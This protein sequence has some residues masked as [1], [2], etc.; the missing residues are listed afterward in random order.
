MLARRLSS[1]HIAAAAAVVLVILMLYYNVLPDKDATVS[2][3]YPPVIDSEGQTSPDVWQRRA[4]QV[5]LAFLHAYRGYEQHAS[6]HDELLPLSNGT[7][8]NFNGW[9]VTAF[10]SLDTM[11]LMGLDNEFT[12]ALL[13]VE[14]A[15]FTIK[16]RVLSEG[17]E[18]ETYAPF[19]ETVI[20]YLGG[21]L[22]A[23]ALSREP[24]LLKRADDL[25]NLLSPVFNTTSGLP[26]FGVNTV[27]F[28]FL[29][30]QDSPTLLPLFAFGILAEIASCQLEYTYLARATA[31]KEH[32]DRAN[33][34]MKSL[35]SADVRRTGDMF[36]KR[37]NLT[38]GQPADESLSVGA[39]A[40]S[41]H[42][43]LLKQYLLTA[44]SDP[45]SLQ[46]Y[47][48]TINHILTHLLYISDTRG[49]VYVTDTNTASYVPTHRFEHLSCFFPGLLALGAHTL[50]FSLADLDPSTLGPDGLRSYELL[51]KYDLRSLHMW[52]AEGIATSCW[53]MYADQSSGLGPEE[54]TMRPRT[55][56][57][58]QL[59]TKFT[60]GPKGGPVV[61]GGLLW[62]D[63]MERWRKSGARGVPPGLGD[64]PSMKWVHDVKRQKSR[65]YTAI[66]SFY[67]LW[68]TTGDP[69]W[70]ERGWA[71]FEAI[72]RESKTMSG[73]ASISNVERSPAPLRDDMPSYFLAET[74]KYLYLLFHEEDMLPLDRW[75]FNTEAHPLP[76][77]TWEAWE[78][79]KF[80]I[81][82]PPL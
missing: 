15:S 64:K 7:K 17:R 9:G 27:N 28:D 47:L 74:L 79:K 37:W 82:S 1:R 50:N 32:Y 16:P 60:G 19:F 80:G 23:Y 11:I 24:M 31:K 4:E 41:A 54:V 70:R 39:A 53:L 44:R 45:S 73:Y 56:D 75:V 14:K 65:D 18:Q 5:K 42:E 81:P 26:F 12:R 38:S 78:R 77:F 71:V 3:L 40:D 57:S 25:A 69:V 52:A 22:S 34:I 49:L 59:S 66:E 36:P 20:R 35:A 46:M 62:I 76:V 72:E 8:D 6:P 30:R 48:R 58:H 21:L 55:D 2:R 13:L 10:D 61:Q 63:E 43:Y 68:R 33:K 67:I 51:K 29:C